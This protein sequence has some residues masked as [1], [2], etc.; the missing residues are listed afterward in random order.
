MGRGAAQSLRQ[1]HCTPAHA[2]WHH[3]SSRRWYSPQCWIW[4]F[5]G[6]V[7]CPG[8]WPLTERSHLS[9]SP[10]EVIPIPHRAADDWPSLECKRIRAGHLC[11]M[12]YKCWWKHLSALFNM[13]ATGSMWLSSTWHETKEMNFKC[14]FILINFTLNSYTWLVATIL[15]NADLEPHMYQAKDRVCLRPPPYSSLSLFLSYF[16]PSFTGFSWEHNLNQSCALESLFQYFLL[17][18]PP[19]ILCYIF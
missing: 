14:V 7:L 12:I 5:V 6:S 1:K 18:N 3:D 19:E 4:S 13:V 11:V 16:T 10:C 2:R 17:G 8:E 9:G 15:D